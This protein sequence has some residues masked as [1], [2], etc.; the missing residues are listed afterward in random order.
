M[1]QVRGGDAQA[2]RC[3]DDEWQ[4]IAAVGT[5]GQEKLAVDHHTRHVRW[6]ADSLVVVAGIGRGDVDVLPHAAVGKCDTALPK[7]SR[8]CGHG[9]PPPASRRMRREA[10]ASTL[11][12]APTHCKQWNQTNGRSAR[13]HQPEA[14][15]VRKVGVN[16]FRIARCS[17]ASNSGAPSEPVG[18]AIAVRIINFW[19]SSIS[20]FLHSQALRRQLVR[21]DHGGPARRLYRIADLVE[22]LARDVLAT[23]EVVVYGDDAA[24][25]IPADNLAASRRIGRA[26]LDLRAHHRYAIV[27][28]KATLLATD[29]HLNRGRHSLRRILGDQLFCRQRGANAHARA[30]V[31]VLMPSVDTSEQLAQPHYR[32]PATVLI[33]DA[34][35]IT[36]AQILASSRTGLELVADFDSFNADTV[37]LLEIGQLLGCRL[38]RYRRNSGNLIRLRHLGRGFSLFCL[39][40]QYAQALLQRCYVGARPRRRWRDHARCR[41]ACRRP[42]VEVSGQR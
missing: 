20:Y 23:E 4:G 29:R 28:V 12:T 30:P 39:F 38:R 1:R 33:A 41:Q 5:G 6:S 37:F 2:A 27:D 22:Q 13:R 31:R 16:D 42:K 18:L 40:L 36:L 34:V 9:C 24:R 19:R 10:L 11:A 17:S 35:W 26:H 7:P 14:P 3:D 32:R 8:R 25:R 15:V 21:P